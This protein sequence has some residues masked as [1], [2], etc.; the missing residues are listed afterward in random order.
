MFYSVESFCG[1]A[2]WCSR[3]SCSLHHHDAADD[4]HS[5]VPTRPA[6]ARCTLS[7]VHG[8]ARL[9]GVNPKVHHPRINSGVLAA[10]SGIVLVRM[11]SAAPQSRRTRS[12]RSRPQFWAA[13]RLQAAPAGG[14]LL[15]RSCLQLFTRGSTSLAIDAYWSL[16]ASGCLLVIALTVDFSIALERKNLR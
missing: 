6:R 9:A 5:F 13:S 4:C 10:F 11:Q 7:A 14:G 8:A 2:S 16:I 15:Y 1:A 3:S 12:Q